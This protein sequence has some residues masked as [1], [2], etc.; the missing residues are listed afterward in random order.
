MLEN[1]VEVQDKAKRYGGL[2]YLACEGIV[3]PLQEIEAMICLKIRKPT[4]KE[5]GKCDMIEITSSQPWHPN[6]LTDDA[7]EIKK[8][9]TMSLLTK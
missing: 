8:I 1:G 9:S 4:E 3:L 6:D 7:P 2:P 5:I